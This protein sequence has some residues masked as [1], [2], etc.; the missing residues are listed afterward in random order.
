VLL[1][2]ISVT[3]G[4]VNTSGRISY[5]S[6]E[7]W[8]FAATVRQNIT[9]GAPFD[10]IRYAEVIRVCAL[11]SDFKQWAEGDQTVVGERGTSLSGG[12]RA[13]INLARWVL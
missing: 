3:A 13:R 5:A 12:Q 10:R 7:A 11:E 9:F 1:G 6:Q 4:S 8:V 2:E